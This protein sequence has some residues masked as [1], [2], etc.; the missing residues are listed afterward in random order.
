MKN[1]N[2][3]G[4]KV[5][6]N[7]GD[8]GIITLSSIAIKNILLQNLLNLYTCHTLQFYR[9]LRIIGVLKML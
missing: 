4:K 6:G 5:D 1:F 8:R 9:E 3:I 2:S 7:E